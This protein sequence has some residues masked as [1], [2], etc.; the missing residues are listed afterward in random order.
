M[1]KSIQQFQTEGVKKL[2]KV[3]MEYSGD[4]TRFAEMVYG[5]RDGVLELAR[6]MIVEELEAYDEWL[7]KSERRKAQWQIV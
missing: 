6:D 4:M 1:I 2:E 7:R 3:F 5:V